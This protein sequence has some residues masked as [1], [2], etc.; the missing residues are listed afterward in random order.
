[1]GEKYKKIQPNRI[2]R[3]V[4]IFQ[5]KGCIIYQLLL[6]LLNEEKKR[7][8]LTYKNYFLNFINS[9]SEHVR[10][11]IDYFLDMLKCQERISRKFVK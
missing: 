9:V 11:K 8:I 5:V 1:M 6:I 2:D 7:R 3:I 10:R 4:Q